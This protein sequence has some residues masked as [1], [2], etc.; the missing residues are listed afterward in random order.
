MQLVCRLPN[1]PLEAARQVRASVSALRPVTTQHLEDLFP[2]VDR[3]SLSN[4]APLFV[5]NAD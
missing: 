5:R 1:G 2:D 4:L 3:E